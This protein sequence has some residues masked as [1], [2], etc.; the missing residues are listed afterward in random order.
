MLFT[1]LTGSQA[2]QN[3]DTIRNSL[4]QTLPPGIPATEDV[5]T[6][7][8]ESVLKEEVQVWVMHESDFEEKKS[9]IHAIALTTIVEE[10]LSN[11]KSL[12]IYSLFG[13][14]DRDH[15]R[16]WV[17]GYQALAKFAK[18]RGCKTI[19]GYTDVPAMI[20]LAQRFEANTSNRFIYLE[21]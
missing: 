19:S 18:S 2:S 13:G 15:Q 21:V 8:L 7:I 9:T 11:V 17:L 4:Y 10:K 20:K 16:D 5:M 1:R 12:L 6:N 3:W 14:L